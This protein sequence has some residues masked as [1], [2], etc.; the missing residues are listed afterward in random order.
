MK[1]LCATCSVRRA[2]GLGYLDMG[3]DFTKQVLFSS[4]VCEAVAAT[5]LPVH[6]HFGWHM[7]S[8]EILCLVQLN[9]KVGFQC[10]AWLAATEFYLTCKESLNADVLCWLLVGLW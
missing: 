3:T 4:T 5:G 2:E 6:L 1:A 8:E 9:L 7:T 10:W